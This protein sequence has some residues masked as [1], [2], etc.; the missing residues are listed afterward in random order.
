MSAWNLI[1]HDPSRWYPDQ[2]PGYGS[3][4][5]LTTGQ[6]VIHERRPYR[7]IAVRERAHDLWPA[8]FRDAWVEHGSPDVATWYHRPMAITLQ[9][10]LEP[11]ADRIHLLGAGDHDW[12]VLPE[13]FAVCWNC[14]EIP[15]CRHVHD[16]A[17]MR[18]AV[19]QLDADMAIMPGLCH[20]CAGP[21]STRQKTI[22]FG[23]ENL[24]RPDL[25]ENTAIFHLKASCRWAAEKYDKRWA[26]AVEGRRRKL[27]CEGNKR[28]HYDGSMDCTDPECPGDVQHRSAEWHSPGRAGSRLTAGCWCISGDLR[29][30]IIKG[31][32][33][34]EGQRP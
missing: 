24:I 11:D 3:T 2:H 14:R 17:V 1:E 9:P 32:T 23:G 18:H 28:K 33:A 30:R 5:Q 6:V 4:D 29:A 19:A 13:H 16:Q 31:T 22:T 12:W 20:G 7:V 27:F 34:G 15:P 26:E 10:A 8:K 25:G 21:I